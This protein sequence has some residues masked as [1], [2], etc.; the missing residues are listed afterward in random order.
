M[1]FMTKTLELDLILKRI[2]QYARTDTIKGEL[3]VLEPMTDLAAIDAALLE[4]ADMTRLIARLGV[5]PLI[6]DFDIQDL[7]HAAA[8]ER[9]FTIRELLLI[10]LFLTMEQDVL[11]HFREAARQQVDPGVIKNYLEHMAN[12]QPILTYFKQKMDDDGVIPDDATPGLLKIRKDLARLDKQ[13]HEKLQ[14]LLVDHAAFINEPVIVIRN[15]RFCIPFKETFKNKVKGVV[16]DMSASRQTVYIEPEATRGITAQIESLK[17]MEEQEIHTII[18][19][20]SHEVHVAHDSLKGNLDCLLALD[21]ISAKARYALEIHASKPQLNHQ[22]NIRLIQARHPLL[23]AKTV[24]PIDVELSQDIKTLLITGPNTGGKTVALKTVGLLT[25]M[26][27][28]GIMI[29]AK[30]ASDI[31]VFDR[32]FADIGDEQSIMQS[33]STFSS[34]MTKIVKMLEHL[35]DNSL[36][37]LDEIGSGTDP[38]EGV[39]LAIAMIDA[40]RKHDIRLMV[41]THYSELK[42]YAYEQ[43][44]MATASVAFDKKSLQPLYHLQMGTTGSSHAFLIARR[45][46]LADEIVKQ[47]KTLYR[48]RQT[49]LAR[50][51]EK[52]NDDMFKL[53][54]KKKVLYDE[55]DAAKAAKADYLAQRDTLI[56]EQDKAIDKVRKKEETKW[57][58]LK[59][60]VRTMMADLQAKEA[61]GKPDIAQLKHALRKTPEGEIEPADDEMFKVKDDVFILPYQ[62]PGIIKA[63]KA[64]TY[65]VTFGK[66]TIDFKAHELRRQSPVKPKSV[67][68]KSTSPTGSTPVRTAKLELDLR[69]YRYEEVAPA[70]EDAIDQALLSGLSTLRVIHGFGSGAVR[71]AVHDVIKRSSHVK[72]HRF[73]GEGEGLNGVTIITFK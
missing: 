12:H 2:S 72:S 67:P 4:V 73:G 68:E 38:N 42:S 48:G 40:F 47:A 57:E 28:C 65:T 58:A 23:D 3:D 45:L 71:K 10:R 49:D 26:T 50:I 54:Q 25:L 32:V 56:A 61:I 30:E 66:F 60:E 51:M 46:G 35:T 11:N 53:E 44:H 15:D 29:P 18:S 27:Q 37:L 34:H 43:D 36:V 5:L 70:L 59:D 39:S 21:F 31:A 69:G 19:L 16:H 20:M 64:D 24:V 52:L 7:I 41:T 22:G 55:L 6:D 62:Q 17:V 33:L 9:I 63:V 13:L 14:K 1:R 8:R